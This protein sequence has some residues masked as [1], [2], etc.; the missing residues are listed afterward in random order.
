M[1]LEQL[2]TAENIQIAE[3]F[4]SRLSPNIKESLRLKIR[5]HFENFHPHLLG[6]HEKNTLVRLLCAKSIECNIDDVYVKTFFRIDK[7][8]K[9]LSDQDVIDNV[10]RNKRIIVRGSCLLYTSPSPRDS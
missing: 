9:T 7:S 5:K 4:W 8:D 6:A 1:A 10:K 2:L 3:A